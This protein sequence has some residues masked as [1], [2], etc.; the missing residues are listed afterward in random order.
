MAVP[1]ESTGRRRQKSRTR[2]ALVEAAHALL[3]DGGSPT[4]ED[5]AAAAGISRTTAY[6]YFPNQR[7]LL[8]AAYPEI[9]D[10]AG[11]LPPDAPADPAAR[12]ELVMREFIA[13]T[14]RWEP[15]LRA[16]LRLS[17]EPGAPQP[18]L[19]RGRAIRWI[20]EA[21]AP[22]ADTHPHLDVHGL[23]TAIRSASGIESLVWLTD[24]GGLDRTRAAEV[25]A[26]SARAILREALLT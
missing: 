1:Y 9:Q 22:L 21:L 13:F 11:L 12:L 2:A 14:L 25:L 20:E 3:A 10:D 19:R 24:I 18:V 5:A 7:E 26:G 8:L 23:A 16:Q 15:Q 17:L 4:V 6:R